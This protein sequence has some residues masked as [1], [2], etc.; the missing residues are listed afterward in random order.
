MIS[1]GTV[2]SEFVGRLSVAVWVGRLSEDAALEALSA[3]ANAYQRVDC[4]Q[5]DS[6]RDAMLA[7]FRYRREGQDLCS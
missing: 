6:M 2:T 1:L 4:M 5:A 3:Y 7:E